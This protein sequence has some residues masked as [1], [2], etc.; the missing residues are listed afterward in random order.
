M[1]P[2]LIVAPSI[3]L[4]PLGDLEVFVVQVKPD[5]EVLNLRSLRT[6]APSTKDLALEGDL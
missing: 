3:K 2:K 1:V 6:L 4:I 5:R